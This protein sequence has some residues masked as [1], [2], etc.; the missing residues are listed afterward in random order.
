MRQFSFLMLLFTCQILFAG[1]LQVAGN[2]TVEIK[3]WK[4]QKGS[5]D[6]WAAPAFDDSGWANIT[7]PANWE[8]VGYADYDGY[9]WYRAKVVIPS[10]LKN[11]VG[12]AFC[13]GKIDDLDST[14]VNGQLIGSTSRWDEDRVYYISCSNPAIRWDKE[15][16]IAVKVLD[17]SGPGG[18]FEGQPLIRQA[19]TM[20][21][22]SFDNLN[23]P[24]T[25]SNRTKVNK[26]IVIK[27]SAD[28]VA[29]GKLEVTLKNNETGELSK[30]Q[31]KVV[32]ITKKQPCN[33][34]FQATIPEGVSYGIMYKFTEQESGKT[35]EAYD[36]VPYILTP[37][38]PKKPS[39]NGAGVYAVRPG[40]PVIYRMPVTGVRPMTFS[41]A[42]LPD[43]LTFD[44]VQGVIS[45]SIAKAGE[46]V[47]T[48]NAQNSAGSAVKKLKIVVGQQLALTP[49]MGWNSWNCWGLTVDDRKVR[50]S[51]DAF[52]NDGLADYG[53]SYINIDDGWEA[54]KRNAKGEI[55]ANEKFP[56][57]KALTEYVHSKGLKMGLYSSPGPTTC[58]GFLGSYQH[59]EQDAATWSKW[60]FDYI[61]YDWCGY[62]YIKPNATLAEL[63][64]PYNLMGDILK[65]QPRDIVYSLCQYGMGDV[66]KWG[67]ETNGNLWRT[68]GDITDTWESMSGIG[69]SQADKYPYAK[70]GNWNDPD[71]LVVGKLGWGEV[72][73]NRLTPDEQYTHISLWSL[74]SA[75]LLIGCDLQ[76]MDDFTKNLLC[77][78]EV[79][80]INQDESGKQAQRISDKDQVQIFAKTLADGSLAVGLF[81]LSDQPKK[82]AVLSWTTL[83]IEGNY[84]VRDVWR[85]K[86]LGL[87]H[88]QLSVNVPS[89][90]VMLLRL[91]NAH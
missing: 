89:H 16:I 51:A 68:T 56:D 27:T 10:A 65:R 90:G 37:K 49:P 42:G 87:H 60:G 33:Y 64:E 57:M 48:L 1:S 76:Q 61:K 43:G 41:V 8:K 63:K 19:S 79:I 85:Q 7:V 34:R 67:G 45:G 24:V 86:D 53:W 28:M 47:V 12:L 23:H 78:S 80:A 88:D 11:K 46:Y 66:W 2:K 14:F 91:I 72:R 74:L 39:I 70:P 50:A 55:E 44:A 82:S 75:P 13:M 62:T 5:N 36:G 22:I 18:M 25:V 71:M 77:N 21:F 9:A 20:E 58:G 3:N 52:I 59:E 6:R 40:S 38:A 83:N 84:R 81:N 31:T 4:F 69:F 30:M 54:P 26:L 35:M 29:T 73:P 17:N 32:R 15:N